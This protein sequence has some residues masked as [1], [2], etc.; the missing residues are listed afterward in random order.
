MDEVMRIFDTLRRRYRWVVGVD[1]FLEFAFVLTA[2]AG[3]LLLLDR[4]AYELQL[5]DL[6]AT[7]AAYVAA[8]F[9]TALAVAA[10][11]AVAAALGR[12]IPEAGLAWRTDKVLGSD[13]RV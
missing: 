3:S 10:I 5:A 4:I 9:A 11:A 6:H 8:T 7:K 1:L 13:E 2:A 12:R